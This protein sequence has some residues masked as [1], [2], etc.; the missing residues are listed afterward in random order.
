M[1]AT[2]TE[3]LPALQ[4][5]SGFGGALCSEARRTLMLLSRY[6]KRAGPA[7]RAAEYLAAIE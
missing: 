3:Y 2:V 7:E 4:K 5:E 6:T 1:T